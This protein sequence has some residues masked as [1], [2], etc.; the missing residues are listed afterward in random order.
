MQI[1]AQRLMAQRYCLL[2]F[3]RIFIKTV[4]ASVSHSVS[5]AWFRSKQCEF[6]TN[7]SMHTKICYTYTHTVVQPLR[8]SHDESLHSNELLNA[9][10]QLMQCDD[11]TMDYFDR[12]F[13]INLQ[14]EWILSVLLRKSYLWTLFFFIC[15]NVFDRIEFNL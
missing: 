7:T 15:Q 5:T 1:S 11:K 6:S 9:C 14:I 13:Q 12:D 3:Y 8:Q 2:F 10:E 4:D